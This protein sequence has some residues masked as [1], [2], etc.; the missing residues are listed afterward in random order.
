MTNHP[1]IIVGAGGFGR[2]TLD[3]VAASNSSGIGDKFELLGIVDSAPSLANLARL[4]ARGIPYLGTVSDWLATGHSAQYLIG[5]GSPIAREQLDRQFQAVGLSAAT[6]VHPAATIGSSV[7]ID[8]GAV[9]CAGVQVST[10]VVVGR[11]VHLNPNS[12]I[13][14]DSV[15][16]DFVSV[17]PAATISG[18]VVVGSRSMI[19]AAAVILQGLTVGTDAIVGASSCVVRNVES[20]LTVKGVPAG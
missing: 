8:D 12:T 1:L 10:N 17:N 19:G 2:E 14:H 5:I 20:G 13:G 9:V 11:H 6:V 7:R 15:L 16:H 4:A 3:V 18:D